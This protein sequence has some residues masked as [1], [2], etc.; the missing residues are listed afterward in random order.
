M[1]EG[2]I[3]CFICPP[4]QWKWGPITF[5]V[6]NTTFTRRGIVNLDIHYFDR[7]EMYEIAI[8]CNWMLSPTKYISLY[9]VEAM[10]KLSLFHSWY[11]LLWRPYSGYLQSKS[12]EMMSYSQYEIIEIKMN[13]AQKAKNIS[14]EISIPQYTCE[15]IVFDALSVRLGNGSEVQ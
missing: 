13:F 6:P 15:R 1:R 5:I 11:S 12:T 10:Y 7:T 4:R 3:W 8:V 2:C 14:I 9:I